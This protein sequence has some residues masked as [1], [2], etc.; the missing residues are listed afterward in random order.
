MLPAFA[1]WSALALCVALDLVPFGAG[2]ALAAAVLAAVISDRLPSG[3]V[4]ALFAWLTSVAVAWTMIQV[5]QV[6]KSLV[7]HVLSH[8]A[9]AL[10]A[11]W[12]LAAGLTRHW[13]DRWAADARA[14]FVM[15]AATAAMGSVILLIYSA[16]GVTYWRLTQAFG[17]EPIY[18]PNT[19]WQGLVDIVLVILAAQLSRAVG[20]WSGLPIAT[21]WL[22][23]FAGTWWGLMLPPA[24]AM[25]S[26]SWPGWLTWLVWIQT[27]WAWPLLGAMLIW[28]WQGW[29]RQERAWPD[30]LPSLVRVSPPWPGLEQSVTAIGLVLIPL[31]LWHAFGTGPEGYQIARLTTWT[32]AAGAL[33]LSI[34]VGWRWSRTVAELALSL[35]TISLA[36]LA[37]TTALQM[38]CSQPTLERLPVVHSAVLAGLAGAS[39]LWF[40]LAGFWQ[41]QLQQ[42][43]P[44]TIAGRLIPL[45]DRVGFLAAALAVLV[46]AKLAMWPRMEYGSADNSTGRLAVGSLI[47]VLLIAI[48][49]YAARQVRK[50]AMIWLAGMAGIA[51]GTFLCLRW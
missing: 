38:A 44:W 36:A 26:T 1:C 3:L 49:L 6:P 30:D 5:A 9:A 42:G 29:R 2:V 41:Q 24:P 22:V 47:Y 12:M 13:P 19:A 43:R 23:V 32:M 28:V 39:L 33:A 34:F 40:W 48:C 17:I 37:S 18:L 10:A 15:T 11:W 46:A 45:A 35:W 21:L 51:W 4:W 8:A 20:R 7:P 25:T 31:G 16:V 14:A 50:S 27:A